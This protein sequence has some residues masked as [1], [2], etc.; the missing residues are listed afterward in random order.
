[1]LCPTDI[2]GTSGRAWVPLAR[3]SGLFFRGVRCQEEEEEAEEEQDGKQIHTKPIS[4]AIHTS[5]V[6]PKEGRKTSKEQ[7]VCRGCSPQQLCHITQGAKGCW[8]LLDAS[9]ARSPF[10]LVSKTSGR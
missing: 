8:A 2:F 9:S 10:K 7:I 4:P 1:M 3:S 6:H 5:R